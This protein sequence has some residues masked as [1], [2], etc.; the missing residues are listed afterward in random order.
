MALDAGLVRG[1]FGLRFECGMAL[2]EMDGA[3]GPA[4]VRIELGK[5]PERIQD[6]AFST[7]WYEASDGRFLLRAA[8][9]ASYYVE[10]GNRIVAQPLGGAPEEDVRVFLLGSA[11]PV[12]LMQRGLVAFHGAAAAVGGKGV[13]ILGASQTGKTAL[14]LA[15]HDRGFP[16]LADEVCAVDVRGDRAAILPGVPQL[17]A[18]RDTLAGSGRQA[19]DHRPIRRGLEKYAVREE[20][21]FSTESAPLTHMVI[22]KHH[23]RPEDVFT[24]VTGGKKLESAI[25]GV[26]HPELFS[27]NPWFFTAL[28]GIARNSSIL[29]VTY[30]EGPGRMRELAE[31]IVRELV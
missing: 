19:R 2:P 9:I 28:A 3:C 10:N 25:R 29:Q 6:A 5:A 16:L 14:A 23:N 13:A 1:A 20:N 30:R 12:L 8:G 11:L 22:L 31:T 7:P 21:M 15:L 4:D 18:W 17:N 24:P 26:F 27:K